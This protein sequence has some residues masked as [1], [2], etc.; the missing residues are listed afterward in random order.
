M[1]LV[2]GIALATFRFRMF[3]RGVQAKMFAKLPDRDT[4]VCYEIC[5]DRLIIETPTQRTEIAWSRITSGARTENT[6]ECRTSA[7]TT[8]STAHRW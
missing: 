4:D 7:D 1:L 5:P 8:T 6:V 2:F 3:G